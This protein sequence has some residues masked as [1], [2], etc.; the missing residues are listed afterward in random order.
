MKLF[1]MCIGYIKGITQVRL[2]CIAAPLETV[3]DKGRRNHARWKRLAAVMQREYVPQHVTVESL[4]ESRYIV[5][6]IDWGHLVYLVP[7]TNK[8][9]CGSERL[10]RMAREW[11]CGNQRCMPRLRMQSIA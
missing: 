3:F 8:K 10:A 5:A 1:R 7:V 4:E 11:I 6:A 9:P 2:E